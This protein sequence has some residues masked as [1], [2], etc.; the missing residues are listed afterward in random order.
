VLYN[1]V[2]K[3]RKPEGHLN[4]ISLRLEFHDKRTPQQLLFFNSSRN[5][6]NDVFKLERKAFYWEQAITQMVNRDIKQRA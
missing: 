4:S 5:A 3:R 6:M 2:H 1:K